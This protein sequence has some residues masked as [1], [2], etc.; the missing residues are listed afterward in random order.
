MVAT[1]FTRHLVMITKNDSICLDYICQK[2]WM[3]W[4]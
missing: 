4:I 3:E 1:K 2:T